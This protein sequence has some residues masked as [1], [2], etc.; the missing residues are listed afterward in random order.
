MENWLSARHD[1]STDWRT[2]HT[3]GMM[4]IGWTSHGQNQEQLLVE[5]FSGGAM[6]EGTHDVMMIWLG[7]RVH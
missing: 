6:M 7:D 4:M 2:A 5:T 1:S 3:L